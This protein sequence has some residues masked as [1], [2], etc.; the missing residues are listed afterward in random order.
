M[1]TAQTRKK[2]RQRRRNKMLSTL[3]SHI[4]K[5]L[6]G[7]AG[8]ERE[9]LPTKTKFLTALLYFAAAICSNHFNI[10]KP[11]VFPHSKSQNIYIYYYYDIGHHPKRGGGGGRKHTDK[12]N[13]IF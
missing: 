7:K 12:L 4:L 6:N 9:K 8:N 1:D 13:V 2:K 10:S 11:S 3:V 5:K